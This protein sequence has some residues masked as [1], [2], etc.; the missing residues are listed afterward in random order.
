LPGVATIM[1]ADMDAFYASVEQRENPSLVGRPVVV[2]GAGKRGVVAAASY[3]ARRFGVRSAMPMVT[4]RRLCEDLVILPGR[5]RLYAGISAEI[6][7]IFYRYTPVIE[8]LS[9]DEAYLDVGG[10]LKLFGSVEA[11][12][13]GIRADI[14]SELDLPVS[15][16]V[17]PGKLVAKIASEKAKPDGMLVV[18]ADA[19]RE[20]LRPLSVSE[21]WGVGRVTQQKLLDMG[22]SRI[23][24]LADHDAAELERELGSWGPLLHGLANAEDL[25]TVECDRGR[26][27][28]GEENTFP[29]DAVDEDL[30]DATIIA[31]AETVARRLRRDGL[32]GRTVTLKYRPSGP[33]TDFKLVTRSSTLDDP[34]DDGAV[35]ARVAL[36]LWARQPGGLAIRLV[37]VQVSALDGERP[38]QLALFHGPEEDQQDALNAAL[39]DIVAKFGP[40]AVKRGR[41]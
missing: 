3:E 16:G 40:D 31:H 19:A 7:D 17:G 34:T 4:A 25:R 12:G 30:I 11:I 14:R 41:T 1:H 38:V 27:S 5:M 8:P 23:G 37:G 18:K 28:Y 9:L 29:N 32:S 2:G 10:S 20:F 26:K 15:V 36:G 39:D 22:I 6:R 24:Q 21:I 13:E 35:I 33:G